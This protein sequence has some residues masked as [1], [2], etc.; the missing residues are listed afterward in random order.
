[1]TE[2]E[3]QRWLQK[4]TEEATQ[5]IEKFGPRIMVLGS[6]GVGKSSVLNACF[7]AKKALVGHG[8]PVTGY[9]A[10][11]ELVKE[12]P[13][14]PECPVHLY[15]SKGFETQSKSNNQDIMEAIAA[16]VDCR[17]KEAAKHPFNSSEYHAERI[18]C[19]WWVT[20]ERCEDGLVKTL[21]KIFTKSHIPII[22]VVNKCDKDSDTVDTIMEI[23]RQDIGCAQEVV[24]FVSS[25]QHGPLRKQCPHCGSSDIM[26]NAKKRFFMCQNDECDKCDQK[27]E[28]QETYGVKGL[29]EA[30]FRALPDIIAASF[31]E[32]QAVWLESLDDLAMSRVKMYT[33]TAVS[34]SLMNQIPGTDWA[35]LLANETLMITNL[36]NVYSL[37]INVASLRQW[38]VSLTGTAGLALGGQMCASLLKSIPGVGTVIGSLTSA[39]VAGAFTFGIGSLVLELFRR[40]RGAALHGE[41]TAEHFK[42]VMGYEEQKQWLQS[43]MSEY[44]RSRPEPP[45]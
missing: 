32:S 4:Q 22:M 14:T 40:V 43:A 44:W 20:T 3:A 34:A 12:F 6:T 13:K 27:V 7:G 16:V 23:V 15:D 10:A 36:A 19:V 24:P 5:S 33:G 41:I 38:V 2:E 18:H 9:G 31:Q 21:S 35:L 17:W 45:M 37:P 1:M 25:A 29:I 26:V 42:Q 8:R 11:A 39:G 28:M 30:T